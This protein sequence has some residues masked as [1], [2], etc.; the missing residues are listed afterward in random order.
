MIPNTDTDKIIK[1]HLFK[2]IM[3]VIIN[4]DCY[5]NIIVLPFVHSVIIYLNI[6]LF[7][8]IFHIVNIYN[9]L[10]I[11]IIFIYTYN[12]IRLRINKCK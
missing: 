4:Y 12:E 2:I 11:N 3:Y 9:Y 5:I 1:K 8:N 10:Y 6:I 7:I